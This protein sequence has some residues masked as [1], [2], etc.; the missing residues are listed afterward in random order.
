MIVIIPET[1]I[2]LG[3][4]GFA[5]IYII[6]LCLSGLNKYS[7]AITFPIMIIVGLD[8]WD[9]YISGNNELFYLA[10]FSWVGAI[11]LLFET[12]IRLK[13]K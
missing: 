1:I 13:N 4:L 12:I 7:G 5:I 9:Y 6:C 3:I 10:L 11:F 8:Y 2:S